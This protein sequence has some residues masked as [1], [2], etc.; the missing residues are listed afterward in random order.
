MFSNKNL[1]LIGYGANLFIMDNLKTCYL[2]MF[3]AKRC[4]KTR[5]YKEYDLGIKK[6]DKNIEMEVRKVHSN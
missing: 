4:T 5:K 2:R 3:E 6:E 1:S